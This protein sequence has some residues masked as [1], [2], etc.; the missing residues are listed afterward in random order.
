MGVASSTSILVSGDGD[1]PDTYSLVS[2]ESG[3][4][5]SSSLISSFGSSYGSLESSLRSLDS[6]DS[7]FID[8]AFLATFTADGFLATVTGTRS[9]SLYL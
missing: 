3:R 6:L 4:M 7:T 1:V 5:S 8:V 2:S 9:A